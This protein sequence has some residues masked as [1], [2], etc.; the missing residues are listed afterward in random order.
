MNEP[1]VGIW[2]FNNFPYGTAVDIEIAKN[3]YD[4]CSSGALIK[5]VAFMCGDGLVF[6]RVFHGMIHD[7][8]IRRFSFEGILIS[9]NVQLGIGSTQPTV[10]ENNTID[11]TQV[12]GDVFGGGQWGIRCDDDG[13]IINRNT[14]VNA[15]VGILV[16]GADY[17]S[18]VANV[19]IT[20]NSV[21]MSSTGNHSMTFGI[22]AFLASNIKI[23][24]NTVTFPGG[25]ENTGQEVYGIV[26]TGGENGGRLLSTPVVSRN[27]LIGTAN[28][29]TKRLTGI[30]WQWV[31]TATVNTNQIKGF[32]Q[33]FHFLNC[34]TSVPQLSSIMHAN[35]LTDNNQ[36][37]LSN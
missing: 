20:M 15:M 2:L 29:T 18:N 23:D 24:S 4:G 33:A 31:G 9:R 14:I 32:S 19:T 10:I 27:V 26:L 16:Y 30:F 37:Y 6:G 1:N 3:L 17:N 8:V 28:S 35:I 22:G 13:T 21:S 7:N 36:L 12:V 34:G 5:A 11:A 25:M